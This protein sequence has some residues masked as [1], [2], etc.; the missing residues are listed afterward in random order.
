[1]PE[2]LYPKQKFTLRNP[3]TR[4]VLE[5]TGKQIEGKQMPEG[6]ILKQTVN[7]TPGDLNIIGGD[8]NRGERGYQRTIKYGPTP[9]QNDTTYTITSPYGVGYV[10]PKVGFNKGYYAQSEKQ[11]G[12]LNYFDYFK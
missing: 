6:F 4:E 9:L 11:G 10:D 5:K 3:L 8:Y 12:S 2:L 7:G 1:M